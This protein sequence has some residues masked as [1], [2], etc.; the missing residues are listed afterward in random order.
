MPKDLRAAHHENDKNVMKIYGFDE[1]MT[2]E[3]IAVSLL[4]R[5]EELKNY[6]SEH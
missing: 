2:E 3:E 5:Y 4:M 1:S 6:K